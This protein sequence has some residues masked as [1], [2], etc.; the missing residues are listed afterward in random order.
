MGNSYAY[1][2][3]TDRIIAMLEQGTIPWPKSL[4]GPDGFRIRICF[5]NARTAGSTTF[6]LPVPI[7]ILR[8]G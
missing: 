2:Q 7:T 8:T 5:P 4:G 3:I 6:F 1:Q